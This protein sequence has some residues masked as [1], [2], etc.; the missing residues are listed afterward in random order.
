MS[1]FRWLLAAAG[2]LILLLVFWL[3]RREFSGR[4]PIN[5][6]RYL[7]RRV[8]QFGAGTPAEPTTGASQATPD[9]ASG[10]AEAGLQQVVVPQPAPVPEKIVV[11]RLTGKAGATFAGDA[12]VRSFHAAGLR[13]GKFGIFHRCH[14][15]DETTA[16][17]SLASMV[18]PGSFDL[19]RMESE[20]FPGVS[21]FMGLPGPADSLAA[22]DDML[23]TARTLATALEGELL[24]EHGSRL[25]VQRERFLREEIIQ[26]QHRL[27]PP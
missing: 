20:R 10:N 8:P 24:D 22:F 19:G 25:S 15:A 3:S 9:A 7:R 1:E 18:E 26:L 23:S 11:L 2:V 6:S 12:L 4:P 17:F 5:A 14:P 13:H 21:I 16:I 27:P